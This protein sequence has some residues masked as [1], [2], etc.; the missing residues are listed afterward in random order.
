MRQFVNDQEIDE[1]NKF[2]TLMRA[3]CL[4]DDLKM[5]MERAID[6]QAEAY[7]IYAEEVYGRTELVFSTAEEAEAYGTGFYANLK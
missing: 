5:M 4:V 7:G 3:N 6:A 2:S 1:S